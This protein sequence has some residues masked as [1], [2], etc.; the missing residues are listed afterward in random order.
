MSKSKKIHLM[1]FFSLILIACLLIGICFKSGFNVQSILSLI[2]ENHEL[3]M[4][5]IFVLFALKSISIIFPIVAIMIASGYIFVAPLGL[6][7]N[8][9]GGCITLWLPYTIAYK[10]P[11]LDIKDVLIK[12]PKVRGIYAAYREDE[13]FFC[14]FLRIIN[15]LP[16][17]LVSMLMGTIQVPFKTYF[18]SSLAGI[19]PT[20][21]A[22]TMIGEN[23]MNPTSPQF[24]IALMLNIAFS[25]SAWI[26]HQIIKK[27]KR[28]Q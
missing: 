22:I 19:L 10:I 16:M 1:Q 27:R 14:F 3:A 20:I 25:I 18:F 17:D 28:K 4:G 23:I 5:V 11:L 26:I 15:C 8:I 12:Y 9:I 21:I 7:V 2:P 6:I 13:F 24:I